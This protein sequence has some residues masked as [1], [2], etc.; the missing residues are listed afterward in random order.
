MA[1][2]TII[3]YDKQNNKYFM[4]TIYVITNKKYAMENKNYMFLYTKQ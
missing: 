1:N 2:K 4:E 3:R